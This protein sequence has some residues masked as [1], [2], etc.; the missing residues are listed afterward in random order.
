MRSQI[1]LLGTELASFSNNEATS[2]AV[3]HSGTTPRKPLYFPTDFVKEFW[4]RFA[5]SGCC[6][7]ILRD[8]AFDMIYYFPFFSCIPDGNCWLQLHSI[9]APSLTDSALWSPWWDF[10]VVHIF[11]FSFLRCTLFSDYWRGY[12]PS[13]PW[14]F[15][16][17]K[18]K[19]RRLHPW[20]N[21]HWTIYRHIE[22]VIEFFFTDT[23]V[24]IIAE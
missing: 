4:Y 9:A 5:G 11:E 21:S 12:V 15:H 18:S 24:K 17:C 2:K 23:G 7:W 10:P 3:S 22:P 14:G 8:H 16:I 19:S 1:C 20:K 6:S 13:I